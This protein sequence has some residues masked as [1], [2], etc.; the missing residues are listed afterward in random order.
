MIYAYGLCQQG[1]YHVKEGIICQDAY[2]II[3]CGPRM[4][5]GVVADGLGSEQYS[6]IAAKTAVSIAAKYCAE[7]ISSKSLDEEILNAIH[8][9][10]TA[11]QDAIEHIAAENG[12]DADQYDTTLSLALLFEGNLYYGHSGDSGI[13]AL[14]DDGMYYKV[15]EQQ[16]D[17]DGRVFP[18]FFR[19]EKWVFGKFEKKTV[20]A[21]LAT[22]GMYEL[23]FPVYL[24]NETVSIY[25]TLARFFMA[26]DSLKI[27]EIGENAVETNME[28]F[29]GSL[30]DTQVNDDKTMVVIIDSSVEYCLQSDDYYREPDWE[31]LREKYERN[32]RRQAYPNLFPAH[33]NELQ[34][35]AITDEKINDNK[36]IDSTGNDQ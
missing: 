3:K 11:S 29:V 15:T 21:F 25:V 22:D 19:E 9:A 20:S 16:R 8:E 33:N 35:E 4:V 28:E 32:W 17:Q 14:A 26:P 5:I 24:R 6:D 2:N 34:N 1:A 7:K 18:L 31:S 12:H 10:F 30:S 27:A 13:V 23:L 36:S